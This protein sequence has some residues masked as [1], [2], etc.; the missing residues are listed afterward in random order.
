MTPRPRAPAGDACEPQAEE[1][2][3]ELFIFNNT[4]AQAM[5]GPSQ[6]ASTQV[7]D[8]DS[9]PENH[10]EFKP[11]VPLVPDLQRENKVA[12]IRPSHVPSRVAHYFGVLVRP[13]RA[14][15]STPSVPCFCS[16]TLLGL[17]VGRAGGRLWK[18]ESEHG[19][20]RERDLI[21]NDNR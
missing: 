2:E 10:G 17:I 18:V 16:S 12:C 3:E 5:E 13:S 15:Q 14:S 20:E 21:R 7:P 1:E 9:E 11:G 19:E 6:G 8:R 4:Q